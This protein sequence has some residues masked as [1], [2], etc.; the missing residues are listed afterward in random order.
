MSTAGTRYI[1][2]VFELAEAVL[3]EEGENI[4]KAARMI[5]EAA[6]RGGLLHAFGTGHSYMLVEELFYRAGGFAFVNPIFEEGLMLH[7]GARQSTDMERMEGYASVILEHQPTSEGDVILIV[8]NSGRNAVNIEMAM[9]AKA[10]GLKVVAITSL[11]HGAASPSRH[12]S[13][14]RL[15]E[16][17][18]VVI[19]NH[20]CVGDASID[21]EGLAERVAP[22]ST[23]IGAIIVNAI[24]A[25]AA[26]RMAGSG[27][28]P[29]VFA[30]SN[31]N[32]G[33]DHNERLIRKY[34]GVIRCL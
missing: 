14:K 19:D 2:K 13:G 24:V 30:S 1:L 21:V 27:K 22:T 16:L 28:P 32:A 11:T 20:G 18:D 10:R 31:G 29:D 9:E 26:E 5:A 4:R 15:H 12:S 8:S 33:E 7:R 6:G 3:A 23:A 25:E 17:S 34:K